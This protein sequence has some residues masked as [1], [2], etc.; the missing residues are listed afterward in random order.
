M[1]IVN[2]HPNVNIRKLYA[3]Q[4]AAQVGMPVNDLVAMAERGVRKPHV[5]VVRPKQRN[6]RKENAEFVA[7]AVL[8][9][10][11]DSIATWLVEALF[12]DEVYR[13]AFLAIA[14]SGGDLDAALE[15]ADPE[16]RDVLERAAVVDVEADPASEARNLIAAAVRRELA[17]RS[18]S[19]DSEHIRDDAEARVR[20][21]QLSDG[22]VGLDAAGWLL[23]WLEGRM[24]ARA[25][26]G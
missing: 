18:S 9:Q 1:A 22:S 23:G 25:G 11:W 12:V 19:A 17:E 10:S 26:G 3:G 6:E 8:V 7:I 24:E 13:R 20:M 21:E 2:E 16:A 4:V 14:E 5:N 15:A